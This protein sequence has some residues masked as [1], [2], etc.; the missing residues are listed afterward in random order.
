MNLI[1]TDS[2][3]VGYCSKCRKTLT[4][5]LD[6]YSSTTYF[7]NLPSGRVGDTVRATCGHTGIVVD[8][9]TSI[10]IDSMPA[11]TTKSNISGIYTAKFIKG[12]DTLI[13]N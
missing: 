10:V 7:E 12:V 8:G 6:T 5:K 9:S 13:E 3:A 2:V 1:N 11:A 4:G